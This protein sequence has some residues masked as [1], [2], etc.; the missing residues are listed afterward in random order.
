MEQHTAAAA[1]VAAFFGVVKRVRRT[2][3]SLKGG[4]AFLSNCRSVA[5]NPDQ[6]WVGHKKRCR[7]WLYTGD[8]G[9]P[10]TSSLRVFSATGRLSPRR[11][12]SS[13]ISSAI[14]RLSVIKRPISVSSASQTAVRAYVVGQSSSSFMA[15]A[16]GSDGSAYRGRRVRSA[17]MKSWDAKRAN[18]LC[19]VERNWVLTYAG[20]AIRA[21]GF[22]RYKRVV[23]LGFF[24]PPAFDVVVVAVF[25]PVLSRLC[26]FRRS[27]LWVGRRFVE[28]RAAA[29]SRRRRKGSVVA[30]SFVAAAA[31]LRASLS[32]PSRVDPVVRG[33]KKRGG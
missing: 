4:S 28:G 15:A 9:W 32:S 24:S 22:S 23:V 12:L 20:E 5:I 10:S 30:R 21:R 8:G 6:Q 17:I 26:R 11:P 25:V 7:R 13:S 29:R 27:S 18:S 14:A 33:D 2:C 19:G 1:S 3:P 31:F 16:V